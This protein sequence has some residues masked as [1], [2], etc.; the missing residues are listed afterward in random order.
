M[1]SSNNLINK[2]R[3][4]FVNTVEI[5][6]VKENFDVYSDESAIT[7]LTLSNDP[8][9][10]GQPDPG[11]IYTTDT[12]TY[13][14]NEGIKNTNVLAGTGIR[15]NTTNSTEESFNWIMEQD[16]NLRPAFYRAPEPPPPPPS[17]PPP[18]DS[19][20][21]DYISIF[22]IIFGIIVGL[23]MLVF[24]ARRF[25]KRQIIHPI[26]DPTSISTERQFVPAN[27]PGVSV[28]P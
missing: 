21:F 24:V 15:E 16:N 2:M 18:G 23:T 9:L 12:H 19:E 5:W 17:T 13:K 26:Q 3:M 27:T 7:K 6:A 20:E 1:A 22:F 25:S 4:E 14:F 8:N 11:N 28:P 10:T